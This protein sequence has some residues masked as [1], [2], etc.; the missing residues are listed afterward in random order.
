MI[1]TRARGGIRV[2]PLAFR[3][4]Y[5]H[6]WDD[7]R[8]GLELRRLVQARGPVL[9][10]CHA[11]KAGAIGRA[12]LAGTGV[13]TL[14]TPHCF[15]FVGEVSRTRQLLVPGAERALARQC[16]KIIYVCEAELA[17]ARGNRIGTPEQLALLPY[18]VR[19][20]VHQPLPDRRLSELRHGGRLLAN[21][22][23][24][25]RQRRQ[26]VFLDA[27]RIVLDRNEHARVA[28]VGNGPLAPELGAQG[29][30]SDSIAK[31]GSRCCRSR[32]RSS[33]I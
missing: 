2:H 19:G 21:V 6:P 25:R 14:Y 32:L 17:V 8:A 27:A 18:G 26:D 10:H 12:A 28:L 13:A 29:R 23:A 1:E 3:R 33:G 11:S 31:P 15:G 20:A 5:R 4:D 30:G 24:L 7:A 22:S 9:V 16:E